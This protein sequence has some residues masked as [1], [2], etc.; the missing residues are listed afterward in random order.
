[1]RTREPDE[2]GQAIIETLLAL[3]LILL[4]LAIATQAL[5]TSDSRILALTAAQEAAQAAASS[6]P[7]EGLNRARSLLSQ[8]PLTR[9]L[10][11]HAHAT[12]S[13]VTITISGNPHPLDV[14]GTLTPPLRV[15][16]TLPLERY[17][18]D[19]QQP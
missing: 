18:I 16:A 13:T 7:A 12:A 15:E 14:L 11:A 5:I 19:E 6:T 2:Q 3:S 9:P 17:P 1:M 4:T 10:T 8:L